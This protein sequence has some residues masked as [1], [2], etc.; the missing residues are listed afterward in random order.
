M[1]PAV[2]SPIGGHS[3]DLLIAGLWEY[4][5]IFP[6]EFPNFQIKHFSARKL[7]FAGHSTVML[8]GQ[9]GGVGADPLANGCCRCGLM[10]IDDLQH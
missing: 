1:A 8:A 10:V 4:I 9:G 3:L 5:S 6:P 2:M 7:V